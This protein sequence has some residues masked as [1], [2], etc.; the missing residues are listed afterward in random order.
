MAS[1]TQMWKQNCEAPDVVAFQ[2]VD[3]TMT[4]DRKL[5]SVLSRVVSCRLEESRVVSTFSRARHLSR[6]DDLAADPAAISHR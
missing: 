3:R 6:E 1:K 5:H 2:V 4:F